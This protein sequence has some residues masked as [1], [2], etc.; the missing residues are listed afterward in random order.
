MVADYVGQI[1]NDK[2]R[3][4]VLE[5]LEANNKF[6]SYLMSDRAGNYIDGS[7]MGSIGRFFN[8]SC[9]PNM[10]TFKFTNNAGEYCYNSIGL[11]QFGRLMLA[12]S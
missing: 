5:D 12:R 7:K 9:N 10:K 4:K 2:Q 6:N 3:R 11:W 8:S 1:L